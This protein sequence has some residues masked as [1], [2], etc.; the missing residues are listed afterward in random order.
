MEA[1][2]MYRNRRNLVQFLPVNKLECANTIKVFAERDAKEILATRIFQFIET[3][4]VPNLRR[5]TNVN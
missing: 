1:K 2:R 4:N 3:Y 5:F